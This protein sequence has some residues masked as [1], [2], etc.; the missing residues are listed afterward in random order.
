ME[1]DIKQ[2]SDA[3][4]VSAEAYIE[5]LLKTHGWDKPSSKETDTKPGKPTAPLP[6]DCL[7]S[8]Y[9]D[10]GPREGTVEHTLLEK[11][12]KFSYRTLLGE[13]MHA[14]ITAC[15]NIEYTITTLS[16]FF[17][18]PA[19]CHYIYIYL[20][21]VAKYLRRTKHWG[22]KFTRPKSKH[23]S[24]LPKYLWRVPI[25]GGTIFVEKCQMVRLSASCVNE[26]IVGPGTFST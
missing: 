6:T 17:S 19:D 9:Q 12:H 15:P 16:K 3:I 2:Y 24:D 13:L 7:H 26:F 22:I 25:V 4:A 10:Q 20:K 18:T 14:Y 5:R 8:M 21:G 23:L 11:K 1:L